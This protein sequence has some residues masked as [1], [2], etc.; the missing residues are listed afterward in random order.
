VDP[1]D[2]LKKTIGGYVIQI[3]Q[4]TALVQKQAERIKE[5]EAKPEEV[6]EDGAEL[7]TELS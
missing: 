5:L 4:M 1:N 6:K 2:E 3:I 7:Q